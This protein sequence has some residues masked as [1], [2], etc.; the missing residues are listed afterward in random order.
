MGSVA[1]AERPSGLTAS[2]GARASAGAAA[3]AAA[4]DNVA[5]LANGEAGDKRVAADS[6]GDVAIVACCLP[7]SRG[8][9]SHLS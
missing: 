4:T 9:L 2:T 3:R 6:A 7:T 8:L 1:T 5:E